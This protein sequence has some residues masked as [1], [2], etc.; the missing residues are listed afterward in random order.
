M[1]RPCI[2]TDEVERRQSRED[3]EEVKEE[4][5]LFASVKAERS[6]VVAAAPNGDSAMPPS[7]GEPT[8]LVSAS[9][10]GDV[11]M[12][13]DTEEVKWKTPMGRIRVVANEGA[14]V[15]VWDKLSRLLIPL[16][17]RSKGTL[18]AY[19][20]KKAASGAGEHSGFIDYGVNF[21]ASDLGIKK[22]T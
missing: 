12:I 15:C 6:V 22:E 9:P 11:Q 20:E 2:A 1:H 17:R 18:L 7:L 19:F 16:G 13:A 4:A 14:E 5:A 3:E 8:S 21:R 10:L